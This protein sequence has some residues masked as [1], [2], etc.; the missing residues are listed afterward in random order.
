[1][2][3]LGPC[4]FYRTAGYLGKLG[5]I[6]DLG[7][8]QRRALYPGHGLTGMYPIPHALEH[9]ADFAGNLRHDVC[10]AVGIE[11]HLAGQ[12]GL[13]FQHAGTGRLK[14]NVKPAQDVLSRLSLIVY[15]PGLIVMRMPGM[16]MLVI[17]FIHPFGRRKGKDALCHNVFAFG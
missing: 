2:D 10:D 3:F 14:L 17:F 1:M 8:S 16:W 12:L 13:E 7:L 4:Q 6:I 11:L 9:L 5:Q 15:M